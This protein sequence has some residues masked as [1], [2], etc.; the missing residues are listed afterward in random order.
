MRA[1]WS[2]RPKCS[3]RCVSWMETPFT[4]CANPHACDQKIN[5]AN[6]Y[7]NDLVSIYRDLNCSGASPKKPSAEQHGRPLSPVFH[8]WETKLHGPVVGKDLPSKGIGAPDLGSAVKGVTP[9]CADVFRFPRLL[10]IYDPRLGK[11]HP[12]TNT[13]VGETLAELSAKGMDQ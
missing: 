4:T 7:E 11:G 10:P 1:M 6:L 8:D 13:S 12:W 3:H 2:V 5:R 9:I